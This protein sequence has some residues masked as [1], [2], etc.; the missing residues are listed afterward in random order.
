[1]PLIKLASVLNLGV[2]IMESW[3]GVFFSGIGKMES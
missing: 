3:D 1:M 2:Y